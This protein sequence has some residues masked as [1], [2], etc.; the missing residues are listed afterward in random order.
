MKRRI[1][2][3]SAAELPI[4]WEMRAATAMLS[5]VRSVRPA[6]LLLATAAAALAPSS[7][8][9]AGKPFTCEASVLRGTILTAPA[10]EPLV[11]NRGKAC[12]DST[13]GLPDLSTPLP[14]LKVAGLTAATRLT[15]EADRFDL[16][17]AVAAAAVSDLSVGSLGS[18]GLSL[19]L[20]QIPL[21]P[22][23]Q[24]QTI[25]ISS[26][27]G[28]INAGTAPVNG[29]VPL[30]PIP[31]PIGSQLPTSTTVDIAAAVRELVKLPSTDVL[32][33]KSAIA[34]A[35][36]S[37]V[38]G[39]P[40]TTGQRAASGVTVL[41][42]AVDV[43]SFG[44]KSIVDTQMISLA[45][46][47]AN[48]IRIPVIDGLLPALAPAVR[49]VVLDA[50][51]TLPPVALPIDLLRV[52]IRPGTQVKTADSLTQT[53]L[54]VKIAALGQGVVDL[55]LGEAK[56][57]T[58][59]VD[60]TPP[61][62]PA[63]VAVKAP[64]VEAGPTTPQA[65]LSCT[66]RSL[67]LTDVLRRGSR[68]TITGVADKRFVGRSVTIRF[69][70]DGRTAGRALVAPNGT[71]KTT[72]PLPSRRL[73]S[74]NRA[75]YQAVLGRE[76]SLNLKLERRMYVDRLTAK[77]GKVTV[78]GRVTRP[79]GVPRQ[80][81]TLTRRVSCRRSEVVTRFKPRADGRFS[82]TVDAPKGQTA[83]VYRLGTKVRKTQK[84]KKL[85][86][87]FTLPRGVDLAQ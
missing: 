21:P 46:L 54:E 41:G 48:L 7:A 79:L 36:A 84:N 24:S 52:S 74:S 66:T 17:Q 23:L 53:A 26:I 40:V 83:S 14:I 35:G 77:D 85:F 29:V 38:A 39:K 86:P 47:N 32:G 1:G 19:P 70:A 59:G 44:D 15:G 11:A 69:E 18:L 67:V 82:V 2:S 75:R 63:T 43:D 25:D 12:T 31:L 60:C 73:R 37:C 55:A 58:A 5:P 87:T 80:T 30:I 9:A 72:A 16:Q 49:Q 20:D 34:V 33:I 3:R 22:A 57:G 62:P 76:K 8:A 50:I 64:A 56:V 71:F 10:I 81:I 13:A 27:T 51:K 4:Q 78:A 68:V 45:G 28:P 61:P 6:S 42:N 65:A